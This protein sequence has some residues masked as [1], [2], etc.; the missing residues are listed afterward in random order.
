M[1]LLLQP[2]I[3]SANH[4]RGVVHNVCASGLYVCVFRFINDSIWWRLPAGITT[5][6]ALALPPRPIMRESCGDWRHRRRVVFHQSL[7]GS[8]QIW[9]WLSYQRL[10]LSEGER[11]RQAL[12]TYSGNLLVQFNSRSFWLLM[13]SKENY[14]KLLFFMCHSCAVFQLEGTRQ[15]NFFANHNNDNK[16][17]YS[18]NSKIHCRST[19]CHKNWSRCF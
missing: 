6:W 16:T 12:C 10:K 2:F 4:N 1:L 17:R 9:T 5:P 15:S 3:L 13:K 14:D 11:E 19:K 18:N 7:H 8:R